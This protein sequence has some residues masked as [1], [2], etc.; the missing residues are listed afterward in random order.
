MARSA[1]QIRETIGKWEDRMNDSNVPTR[2]KYCAE[3]LMHQ[4]V[5]LRLQEA[6]EAREMHLITARDLCTDPTEREIMQ[7]ALETS[8]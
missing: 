8:R 7:R 4:R 3:Q 1:A 6:K 2:R 5:E